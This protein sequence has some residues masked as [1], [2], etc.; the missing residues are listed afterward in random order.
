MKQ[1]GNISTNPRSDSSVYTN[2]CLKRDERIMKD[3]L[4]AMQ[5]SDLRRKRDMLLQVA[6]EILERAEA[7]N[8]ALT[9]AESKD[10]QGL[11][12]RAKQLAVDIEEIE[13]PAKP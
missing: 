13:K 12:E 8:R 11:I 1:D 6:R 10:C 9:E 5:T 4:K 3:S 2:E 7:A